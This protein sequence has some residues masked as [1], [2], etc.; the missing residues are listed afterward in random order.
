MGAKKQLHF[1]KAAELWES[2][3]RACGTLSCLQCTS[4]LRTCDVQPGKAGP[5]RASLGHGH[6]TSTCH[7]SPALSHFSKDSHKSPLL[8]EPHSEV[9][10]DN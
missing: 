1:K 3:M 10:L 5:V 8:A 2:G 9:K 4:C 7:S 6:T